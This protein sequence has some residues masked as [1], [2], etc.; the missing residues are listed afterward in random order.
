MYPLLLR[1]YND[2]GEYAVPRIYR[3][4]ANGISGEEVFMLS[5]RDKSESTVKNGDFAGMGLIE[6]LKNIGGD[7]VSPDGEF[8][9][10]IKLINTYE[11][12]AVKVYPDDEYAAAHG[13]KSKVSLIYI[14]DCDPNAEMVYG[15]CRDVSPD[16]LKTRVQNGSLSQI[17]NFVNV[18]KGDVFFVPP[19]VIFSI[20]GGITALE[21]SKNSDSEYIISDYGRLDGLGRPRPLQINNALD[22]IKPRK[23]N[24]RYGNTGELTL[25]PFGTV[26]ELGFCDLFKSKLITMDGSVGLYENEGLVSLITL[27]GEL[28]M[29]YSS[30]TM[31]LKAG[32]SVL[33]PPDVKLKLA[34]R[35]E[36]V[37]TKI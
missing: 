25:Y 32:S 16:E 20:G 19:G 13:G 29:S 4:E 15:L 30:G 22:V 31:H 12:Q 6:A 14:A 8:G 21:I 37:Y 34:G 28:D 7:A 24:I 33:V 2:T 5:C 23:I 27:S 35:A 9:V 18:E 36:I 1:T 11:R 26:R 3:G 17:C 10:F